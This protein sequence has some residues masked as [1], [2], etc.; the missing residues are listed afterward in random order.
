MS[1]DDPTKVEIAQ[2]LCE[3]I[4]SFAAKEMI[5]GY[6]FAILIYSP[7]DPGS[8]ASGVIA[9]ATDSGREAIINVLTVLKSRLETKPNGT[10][11][12]KQ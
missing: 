2:A 6:D 9:M 4:G 11:E 3:A 5:V 7:P 8:P 1:A 12:Y 10:G